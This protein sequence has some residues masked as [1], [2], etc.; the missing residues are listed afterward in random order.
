MER[1]DLVELL[2]LTD[3]P[4]TGEIR[5]A[6]K[7]AARRLHPDRAG[8][9]GAAQM[10]EV[11]DACDRWIAEIRTAR[12]APTVTM[13]ATFVRQPDTATTPTAS[14]ALARVYVLATLALM[15]VIMAVIVVVAGPSVTSIALGALIGAAGGAIY[16]AILRTVTRR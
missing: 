2:E 10:A 14:A 8:G 7:Q 4:T 12:D 16:L 3:S 13:P 11:N 5:L 6:R 15:L 9:L 1:A